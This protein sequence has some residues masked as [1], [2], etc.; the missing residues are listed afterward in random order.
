MNCE[1]NHNNYKIQFNHNSDFPANQ[2]HPRNPTP[3]DPAEFIPSACITTHVLI[4]GDSRLLAS[5]YFSNGLAGG[6]SG[7]AQNVLVGGINYVVK[8]DKDVFVH[9]P[10]TST[11]PGGNG[12][13]DVILWSHSSSEDSA[14]DDADMMG[15]T[16]SAAASSATGGGWAVKFFVAI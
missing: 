6:V 16:P 10:D 5:L 11:T 1:V 4:R 9:I 12:S 2:L 13:A 3:S 14:D 7:D 8:T 15:D